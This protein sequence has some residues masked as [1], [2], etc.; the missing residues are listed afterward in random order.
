MSK[1]LCLFLDEGPDPTEIFTIVQ[2]SETKIAIKSGFSRYLSVNTAGEVIGREEAI[3]L[4]EQW[5][6]VFE[7]VC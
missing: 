3:G 4:R 1:L 5:E 2:L 6:P 7:E